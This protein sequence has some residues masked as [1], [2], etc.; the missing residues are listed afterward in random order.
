MGEMGDTLRLMLAS[1]VGVGGISTVVC[2]LLRNGEIFAFS[3][4]GGCSRTH[5][6]TF[7]QL[8]P[9]RILILHMTCLVKLHTR[10][11][12]IACS[13]FNLSVSITTF[14]N[15]DISV[16][17]SV[18]VAY[19]LPLNCP[20]PSLDFGMSEPRRAKKLI[21]EPDAGGVMSCGDVEVL[22][23]DADDGKGTLGSTAVA[24][25]GAEE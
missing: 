2:A 12:A 9:L 20:Y 7:S 14:L 1:E 15:A 16:P 4:V 13:S 3:G 22:R 25:R 23:E 21:L 5:F 17:S 24:E 11:L 10:H 18:C 19:C 6:C 8:V